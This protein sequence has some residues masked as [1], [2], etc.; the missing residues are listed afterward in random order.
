MER[1]KEGRK[2]EETPQSEFKASD[3]TAEEV[4]MTS[5]VGISG[6][7]AI[8]MNGPVNEPLL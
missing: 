4:I 5:Q 8:A 6:A 1:R 7:L 2:E 3:W